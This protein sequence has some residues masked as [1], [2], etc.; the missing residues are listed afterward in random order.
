MFLSLIF[1]G[2]NLSLY[3]G[4]ESLPSGRQVAWRVV[5]S[6]CVAFVMPFLP[7]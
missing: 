4:K 5:V 3:V 1:N 6:V 7:W 2:H